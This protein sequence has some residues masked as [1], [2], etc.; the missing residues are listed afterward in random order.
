M[1]RGLK[2]KDVLQRA[3]ENELAG[4]RGAEPARRVKVPILPSREPCA[5]NLTNA[6]IDELLASRERVAGTGIRQK[7]A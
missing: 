5:L 4:R 7:H 2:L 3:V 6:E 1:P